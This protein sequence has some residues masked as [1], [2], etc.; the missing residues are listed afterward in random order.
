MRERPQS[1]GLIYVVVYEFKGGLELRLSNCVANSSPGAPGRRRC[2]TGP[3]AAS[4][5][6]RSRVPLGDHINAPFIV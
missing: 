5:A 3:R 2:L 4:T 1:M 6:R